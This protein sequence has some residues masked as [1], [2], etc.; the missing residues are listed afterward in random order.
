VPL[1][2]NKIVTDNLYGVDGLAD[3]IFFNAVTAAIL[4]PIMKIAS[5]GYM[6]ARVKRWWYSD[7]KRRL[8]LTQRKLN[9]YHE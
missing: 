1:I 4:N 7:T 2:A 3:V 6:I 9:K 8:Y 5:P